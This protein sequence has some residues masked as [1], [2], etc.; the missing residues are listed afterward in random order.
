MLFI[1][2]NKDPI[3]QGT[4]FLGVYDEVFINDKKTFFDRNRLYGAVGYQLSKQSSFQVGV[5]RQQMNALAK[6]YLQV[7]VIINPDF[8][9]KEE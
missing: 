8:R 9:K 1:P 3:E 5:M 4:V 2:L 6:N 7:A